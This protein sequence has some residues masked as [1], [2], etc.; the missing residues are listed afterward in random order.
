MLL[1]CC[2]SYPQVVDGVVDKCVVVGWVVDKV[3][4]VEKRTHVRACFTP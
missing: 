3:G 2:Y 1:L 4:V